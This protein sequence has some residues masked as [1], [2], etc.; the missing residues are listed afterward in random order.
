MATLE[1][2]NRYLTLAP[3]I[4]TSPT[5]RCGTTL[6]QRL[7]S[8][9]DNALLYGEEI[10][11]HIRALT[12]WFLGLMRG[13]EQMGDALDADFQRTLAG[14]LE[15][16]RPGLAPPSSVMLRAFAETYYQLPSTLADYGRAIGRPVWGFKGPAYS[17]D[18]IRAMLALMPHATVVYMI[19]NPFD[20]LKSAK[21][22]RFV[23]DAEDVAGFCSEWARNVGQA[24]ELGESP[25]MTLL[26]YEDLIAQPKAQI[27]RLESFT[28]ARG[29]NPGV[30][31]IKVNTFA[32]AEADGHS[33]SQ[34]IAPMELTADEAAAV[35]THA[36]AIVAELY[37]E[38][39]RRTG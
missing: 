14:T 16:W 38:P 22:R 12:E 7:I 25:W 27:G 23:V 30:L 13:Q 11:H 17:F 36:G 18:A 1:L 5:T 3:I 6:V 4:V 28:G 19:R 31:D 2:S 26:K 29:V 21:A 20:A 15:D 35:M 8:A 9:S 39:Q 33:P 32:G 34:Y 10:G 24:L 37:G